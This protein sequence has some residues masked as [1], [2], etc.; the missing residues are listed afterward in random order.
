MTQNSGTTMD[1]A[2]KKLDIITP[3]HLT[4]QFISHIIIMKVKNAKNGY[5]KKIGKKKTKTKI[6]DAIQLSTH[7][8]PGFTS[9]NA[10]PSY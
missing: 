8:S 2:T 1:M 4:Q 5:D 10:S 7:C 9:L 6:L 3:I